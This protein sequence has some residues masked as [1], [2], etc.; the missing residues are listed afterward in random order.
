M[1]AACVA[2]ILRRSSFGRAR[3]G[4]DAVLRGEGADG[5]EE[6]RQ[7]RAERARQEEARRPGREGLRFRA[8]DG[9]EHEEADAGAQQSLRQRDIDFPAKRGA[10]NAAERE[11]ENDRP[12]D[13][14]P[15]QGEAREIGA[16]LRDAVHRNDRD[17]RQE[18]R[19]DREERKT[20]SKPEGSRQRR[21]EKAREH[22]KRGDDRRN[23]LRR[24]GGEDVHERAG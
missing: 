21:G 4:S 8:P 2:T 11:P 13:I 12:D 18:S 5:G 23:A 17:G 22:D 10:Q 6:H 14:A 20:P 16:E 1:Q 3:R 19:H 15:L 7:K 24:Q 9:E